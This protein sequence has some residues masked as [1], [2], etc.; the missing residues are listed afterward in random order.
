MW[1]FLTN[2]IGLFFNA[3]R[4]LLPGIVGRVMIALGVG[5]TSYTF[6]LPEILSWIQGYFS[7][8][9]SSALALL[10]ALNVDNAFNLIISA[11]NAKFSMRL[12]A[13]R[14]APPA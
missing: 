13:I 8:L 11:I 9:D 14:L 2:G 3:L 7:S 10:G 5:V 1:E 6:L 12:T 4:N